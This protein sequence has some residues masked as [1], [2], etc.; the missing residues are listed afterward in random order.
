MS[1][2]RVG[3][4]VPAIRRTT[5]KQQSRP[6]SL[7]VG[8]HGRTC[9]PSRSIDESWRSSCRSRFRFEHVHPDLLGSQ[10]LSRETHTSPQIITAFDGV[11]ATRN[12]PYAGDVVKWVVSSWSTLLAAAKDWSA[13][14]R[15]AMRAS[16]RVMRIDLWLRVGAAPEAGPGSIK[17]GNETVIEI[18]RSPPE[19]AVETDSENKRMDHR[20]IYPI[21]AVDNPGGLVGGRGFRSGKC[22]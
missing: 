8:W 19:P 7:L 15:S 9:R 1:R 10:Q 2:S 22:P 17:V 21:A 6:G 16:T 3:R 5:R 14:A 13:T 20:H 12:G 4:V 11:A 18:I